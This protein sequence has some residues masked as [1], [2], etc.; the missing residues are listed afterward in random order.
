MKGYPKAFL[1]LVGWLALIQGAMGL[2]GRF[3]TD[4]EWGLLHRWVDT[5]PLWAYATM[6]IVGGAVVWWSEAD[7]KKT[8]G[9]GA[10]T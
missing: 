8:S 6:L 1:G 9:A 4:S 7:R 10:K 3:F 5:P 2:G